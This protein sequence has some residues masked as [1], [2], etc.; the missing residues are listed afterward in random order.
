MHFVRQRFLGFDVPDVPHFDSADS[1]RWFI[2]RLRTA[3]R[4]L[5]FGTGG[6]TLQAA[7]LGVDFV[8]VDSDEYF[9]NA[10][11]A[12]IR[13]A[14]LERSGQVFR[15]ADLGRVGPWGRPVGR[16]TPRRLELFRRY[17]DVPPESLGDDTMPDLVLV[18]GRFRVA[19]ALKCLY[20]YRVFGQSGWQIVVDDYTGRPEYQVLTRFARLELVG[21]MA[22]LSECAPTSSVEEITDAIQDW[23]TRFD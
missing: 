17:S 5:E 21:R 6:S 3:R 16:L 11:R 19:C 20:K 23:E 14:G 12:K 1:T 8:A 15:H 4:Y 18:D 9:L 22:V 13:A 2:E 7:V 10:V